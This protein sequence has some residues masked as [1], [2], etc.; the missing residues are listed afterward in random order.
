M[1]IIQLCGLYGSGKSTLRSVMSRYGIDG[2]LWEYR[3]PRLRN[4]HR[5][6]FSVIWIMP[7]LIA[8]GIDRDWFKRFKLIL[9]LN[10]L[11]QDLSLYKHARRGV[12]L[13]D[14]G[15]IAHHVFLR[16]R[17]GKCRNQFI[18]DRILDKNARKLA[19]VLDGMIWLD[20]PDHTLIRRVKSRPQPH[21][22]KNTSWDD[23]GRFYVDNRR[24]YEQII[25]AWE[26][27]GVRMVR[28][29]THQCNPDEVIRKVREFITA[30]MGGESDLEYGRC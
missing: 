1:K 17:V 12:L 24:I 27:H 19:G 7:A 26:N 25:S 6:C 30:S 14:E 18:I 9:Y 23:A 5:F 10:V 13:W 8:A 15:P 29:P 20:A 2:I 28:I 22:L 16:V 4:L 21:I 11:A 3:L